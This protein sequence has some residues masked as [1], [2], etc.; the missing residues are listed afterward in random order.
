MG[1]KK[2]TAEDIRK[3]RATFWVSGMKQQTLARNFEVSQGYISKVLSERARPP[4]N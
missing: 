3:I 4:K 1:K 2:L